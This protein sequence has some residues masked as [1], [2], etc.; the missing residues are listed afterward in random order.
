MGNSHPWISWRQYFYRMEMSTQRQTPNLEDSRR[1][2]PSYTPRHWVPT[3]VAFYDTHE[4]RWDYCYP[5]VTTRRVPGHKGNKCN[6]SA[7]QL[8]R[9]GSL[10]PLIGPEPTWTSLRELQ[11][12]QPSGTG[13]SETT[14][15]TAVHPR[16]K[17]CKELPFSAKRAVEF[18]KLNKSQ[19]RQ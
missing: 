17:T 2:W 18:L 5:P 12:R 4:L 7:D 16:T 14:R 1:R 9:G 11:S 19:V 13:L 6:D 15:N 8:V 10:H 3:L